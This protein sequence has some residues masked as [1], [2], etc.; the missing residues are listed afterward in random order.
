MK[1]LY[2]LEIILEKEI[3]VDYFRRLYKYLDSLEEPIRT[4]RLSALM[5]EMEGRFEIP[6]LNNEDFNLAN[7]D[8]MNLYWE[9]SNSRDI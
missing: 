6:M 4:S 9:I 3:A 7:A 5:T 8:V 2:D 1:G